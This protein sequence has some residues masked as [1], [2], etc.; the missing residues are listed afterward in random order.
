MSD[1]EKAWLESTLRCVTERPFIVEGDDYG[2]AQVVIQGISIEPYISRQRIQLRDQ[3]HVWD[4]VAEY[5]ELQRNLSAVSARKRKT[6]RP[7]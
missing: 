4:K 6:A 3:E 5:T 1:E 7:R 2:G